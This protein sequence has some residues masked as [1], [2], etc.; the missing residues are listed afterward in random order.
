MH[1]VVSQ[2]GDQQVG[3]DAPVE[4][5]P[6]R[7]K[8]ELGF[9]ASECRLDIRDP[10]VRPQDRLDIPVDVA[11]AQ[12]IGARALI[13]LVVLGPALEVD[14]GRV[15]AGVRLLDRDLVVPGDGGEA[16]LEAAYALQHPV[17]ALEAAL[18]REAAVE[19][20]Q[21]RLEAVPPQADDRVLG[22]LLALADDVE[23]RLAVLA[24]EAPGAHLLVRAGDQQRLGPA[25]GRRRPGAAAD[26]DPVVAPLAQ[27]RDVL[28][29]GDARVHDHR[30]LGRR[31]A[32]HR[33]EPDQRV[34][35]RARLAHVARQD[36]ATAREACAVERQRQSDQRTIVTLLLGAP[37]AGKLAVGVAVVVDIGE[38]VEGDGVG[39]VQQR[40]L[41]AEQL[42]LDG[43]PVAPEEVAD[44]VERLAPQRLA[45]AFQLE[46]LGGRTVVAQ[47]AAG[48]P[49]AGGMDHPG[50]DQRGC[51][52]PLAALDA[53]VVEDVGEA[54]IVEGLEAQALAA[55][56]AR[57]LVLQGIE[58]DGGDFR[59]AR[60]FLHRLGAE[61]SGPELGDDVLGCGLHVRRGFE[62][63]RAAVEQR[64]GEPGN[65]APFLLRHRIVGAEIEERSVAHP[66]ADALREH[67]AMAS[68]WLPVLVG[69]GF[70]GL[71]VHGAAVA[72]CPVAHTR[73]GRRL[74]SGI[75]TRPQSPGPT[76]DL[77]DH[78]SQIWGHGVLR[79]QH[80]VVQRNETGSIELG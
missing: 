5:V 30:G 52:A 13:G 37:E 24:C 65:F 50:D 55:D 64:L 80:L 73:R 21:R 28:L 22:L 32:A 49:L 59:L 56:R 1:G 11:G 39:D 35:Q 6:D 36:L 54:E 10:P 44:A 26:R 57:V 47:P 68:D 15:G 3:R 18:D 46:K 16:L 53:Q 78:Q 61:P 76:I 4:L 34:L 23:P 41:T 29:G 70:G 48:L 8:A 25:L 31:A 33:L 71:D 43:G 27:P 12:H 51:D 77:Q 67:E 66:V 9:Q 7:A 79:P 2:H 19:P 60:L 72:A 45:V 38:I 42:P 40:A 58:V 14:G 62:Q 74:A 17:V 20:F 69:V 75:S 63:G